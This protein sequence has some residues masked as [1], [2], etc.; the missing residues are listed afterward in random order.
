MEH[1]WN[2]LVIE[3][4]PDSAE[5]VARILKFHKIRYSLAGSAEEALAKLTAVRP[6]ALIVDL[7][8]PGMNGWDLLDEVR[9]RTDTSNIPAIAV[10]AFYS[11]SLAADAVKAGFTACFPKPVEATSF[12][13]EL[14]RAL[15]V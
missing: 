1:D 4:E 14:E 11:A 6:S 8:L 12:V 15:D 10:T 13:K 5:V 3:D 7:A 9:R 2:L